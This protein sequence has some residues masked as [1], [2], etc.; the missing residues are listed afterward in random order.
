MIQYDCQ[1]CVGT[2]SLVEHPT[3]Q[4]TVMNLDSAHDRFKNTLQLAENWPARP[5][6]LMIRCGDIFP[7]MLII[8]F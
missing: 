2:D 4:I 3:G 1:Y 7:T 8:R 5:T 6:A